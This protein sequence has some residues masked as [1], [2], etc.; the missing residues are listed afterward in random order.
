MPNYSSTFRAQLE[1]VN[2]NDPE[3]VLLTITHADLVTPV[4]VCSDTDDITSGG[5]L[6]VATPFYLVM[7]DDSDQSTPRARLA[8]DNTGRELMQWLEQAGGGSGAQLQIQII[9]KA[10]PNAVE[11][12]LTVSL[13]SLDVDMGSISAELG[14]EDV[15]SKPC[16]GLRYDPVVSPGLF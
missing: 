14:Y 9:R 2:D 5:N 4:R 15:M 10:A 13:Q 7:P 3:I 1:G 16:V 6:F 8:I 11:Q 12:D